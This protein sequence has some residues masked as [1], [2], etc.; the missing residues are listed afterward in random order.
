MP[1]LP[2]GKRASQ[3]YW[4][5]YPLIHT[6][7]WSKNTYFSIRFMDHMVNTVIHEQRSAPTKW[8]LPLN[9]G[10]H[11]E[12]T[13]LRCF[14]TWELVTCA[15]LTT[16][17][18]ISHTTC[19]TPPFITEPWSKELKLSKTCPPTLV[20]GSSPSLTAFNRIYSLCPFSCRLLNT[21]M[22]Q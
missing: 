3:S 16:H 12:G 1:F 20:L 15:K 19:R 9:G 13:I 8:Q 21:C 6:P 22:H 11:S 7:V 14:D 2:I 18:W 4:H 17:I 10:K 5:I